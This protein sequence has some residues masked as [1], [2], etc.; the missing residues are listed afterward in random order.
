[1]AYSYTGKQYTLSGVNLN[2]M[3]VTEM[4]YHLTHPYLTAKGKIVVRRG[5]LFDQCFT[6]KLNITLAS[7]KEKAKKYRTRS[8]TL[9]SQGSKK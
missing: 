2:R 1:M 3:N 5:D 7:T 9:S 4:N 6:S 8:C